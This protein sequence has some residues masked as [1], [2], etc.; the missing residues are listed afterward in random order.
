[1]LRL[2]GHSSFLFLHS[3]CPQAPA[4]GDSEQGSFRN[5]PAHPAELATVTDTRVGLWSGDRGCGPCCP[6]GAGTC[7]VASTTRELGFK[8]HSTLGGMASV[9]FHAGLAALELDPAAPPQPGPRAQLPV[10]SGE[11]PPREDSPRRRQAG[12]EPGILSC[13]RWLTFHGRIWSHGHT[14][15]EEAGSAVPTHT[16]QPGC[17]TGTS[18]PPG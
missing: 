8:L 11:L 1:M 7:S 12:D 14:S 17:C 3:H 16:L 10:Q 5:P 9:S 13:W 18:E 2:R 6:C 4:W 15:W